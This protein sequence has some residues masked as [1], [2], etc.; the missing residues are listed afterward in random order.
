MKFAKL[1]ILGAALLGMSACGGGSTSN[2]SG[3]GTFFGNTATGGNNTAPAPGAASFNFTFNS[4]GNANVT[5]LA[6]SAQITGTTGATPNSTSPTRLQSSFNQN[7]LNG[8]SVLLRTL[9]STIAKSSALQAG[10]I[11]TFANP[12]ATP[13]AFADY[14][15]QGQ[16]ALKRWV[17]TGG[18]VTI[19]SISAGT[20]NVTV[21]NLI[22]TP[23]ADGG[24]TASGTITANGTATLTF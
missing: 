1:V 24:N 9:T 21:S 15:E 3:G 19:N 13:G 7:I 23:A 18:T 6:S 14:T 11:F 12:L 20:A 16:P 8:Q 5:D 4:G 10:D 22:L 2:N 17:S